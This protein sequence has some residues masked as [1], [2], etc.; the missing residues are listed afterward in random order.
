[1]TGNDLCKPLEFSTQS[2]LHNE[3][4]VQAQIGGEG[5]RIAG[6]PAAPTDWLPLKNFCN[7]PLGQHGLAVL[8][9]GLKDAIPGTVASIPGC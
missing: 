4:I 9:F 7:W 2:W 8:N 6:L 1:M 5:G 3:R